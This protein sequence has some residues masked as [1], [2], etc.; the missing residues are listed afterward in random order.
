[1]NE[2]IV[3]VDSPAAVRLGEKPFYL[4]FDTRGEQVRGFTS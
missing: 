1:M 3:A 2:R 4:L